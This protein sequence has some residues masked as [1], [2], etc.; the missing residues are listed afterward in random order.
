MRREAFFGS[1]VVGLVMVSY[2]LS[3]LGLVNYGMIRWD[4]VR[5][6][7]V[8]FPP[9]IGETRFGGFF[10]SVQVWYVGVVQGH[11]WYVEF[12]ASYRGNP[13]WRLS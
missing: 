6:G 8:R 13:I 5:L 4:E 1:V 2:G 10:R 7:Q 12:P 11:V 3:R 9:P